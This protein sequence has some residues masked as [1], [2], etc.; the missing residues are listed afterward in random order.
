MV[1]VEIVGNQG[2][3]SMGAVGGAEGVVDVVFAIAS[4][5]LGEIFLR[6]FDG[7]LGFVVAF[8]AFLDATRL[9]F[10]LGIETQVFEHNDL[11]GFHGCHL[12]GGF[13]AVVG[14]LHRTAQQFFQVL[15]NRLDGKFRVGVLFRATEV[16]HQ[17]NHTFVIQYFI[18]SRQ[19]GTHTGVVGD[20]EVVV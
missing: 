6:G 14:K 13:H 10:F 17:H 12:V 4:E 9:A 11:T 19:S 20:V 2:S 5:G 18:D 8:F 7:F 3:G 15:D 16:R 1:G